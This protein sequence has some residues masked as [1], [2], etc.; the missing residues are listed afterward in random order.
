MYN[1]YNEYAPASDINLRRGYTSSSSGKGPSNYRKTSI[2][3]DKCVLPSCNFEKTNTMGNELRRERSSSFNKK[4]TL[5]NSACRHGRIEKFEF[6]V[7]SS[8]S[9]KFPVDSADDSSLKNNDITFRRNSSDSGYNSS[10]KACESRNG[11]RELSNDFQ[12]IKLNDNKLCSNSTYKSKNNG[13]LG[14]REEQF[15]AVRSNRKTSLSLDI[16][17]PSYVYDRSKQSRNSVCNY[18][19]FC[20]LH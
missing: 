4:S 10:G 15:V 1:Y 11:I 20:W 12:R 3:R 2:E 14:Y 13:Q 7:A 17:K 16:S 5:S 8:A 6:G 19:L 9:S 18:L